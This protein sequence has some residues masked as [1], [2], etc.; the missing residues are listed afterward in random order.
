VSEDKFF[1]DFFKIMLLSI[2][3]GGVIGI[4]FLK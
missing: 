1:I 4:A 2:I 3:A